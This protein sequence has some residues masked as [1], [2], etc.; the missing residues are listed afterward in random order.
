MGYLGASVLTA[1]KHFWYLH[2]DVN[3]CSVRALAK[4]PVSC[5]RSHCWHCLCSPIRRSKLR[6]DD[7]AAAEKLTFWGN[8]DLWNKRDNQNAMGRWTPW[9]CDWVWNWLF[10]SCVRTSSEWLWTSAYI[11]ADGGGNA[12]CRGADL[13]FCSVINQLIVFIS[14]FFSLCTANKRTPGGPLLHHLHWLRSV[15]LLLDDH[16]GHIRY[17]VVSNFNLIPAE[18]LS[19]RK[20]SSAFQATG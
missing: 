20:P 19:C 4:C 7:I 9:L 10:S 15:H 17:I 13:W 16:A 18:Q 11:W 1:V 2:N 8:T 5:E 6:L 3:Y 12:M 14:F